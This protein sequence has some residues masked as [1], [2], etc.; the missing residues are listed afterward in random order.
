MN[1]QIPFFI[2]C[3]LIHGAIFFSSQQQD[4][5]LRLMGGL[6]LA[7]NTWLAWYGGLM[8]EVSDNEALQLLGMILHKA[9]YYLPLLSFLVYWRTNRT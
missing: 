1:P 2:F 4:R 9:P 7:F 8:L 6:A 3:L 5:H